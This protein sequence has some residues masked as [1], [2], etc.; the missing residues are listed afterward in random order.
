VGTY[1]DFSY[2]DSLTLSFGAEP[3]D[4]P[5]STVRLLVKVGPVNTY[6]FDITPPGG[7]VSLGIACGTLPKPRSSALV[8]YP[9]DP[10]ARFRLTGFR[11]FGWE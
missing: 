8:F 3:L 7:P 4:A 11:L 6:A 5:L 1:H 10:A 2:Y 9:G